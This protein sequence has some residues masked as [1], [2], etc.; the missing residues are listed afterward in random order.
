MCNECSFFSGFRITNVWESSSGKEVH[1]MLCVRYTELQF[2][3]TLRNVILD[4]RS[5]ALGRRNVISNNV[6]WSEQWWFGRKSLMRRR[7][8]EK[9]K[10]KQMH[11]NCICVRICD[12]CVVGRNPHY[13]PYTT[14][15][16]TTLHYSTLH[17]T[18]GMV[19]YE[20]GA[21]RAWVWCFRLGYVV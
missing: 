2:F 9:T 21:R 13:T 4:Q 16:Y 1:M 17:Y 5:V 6:R 20:M 10:H 15:H 11:S 12:V 7:K 8:E 14:L 18:T 3:T 19:G